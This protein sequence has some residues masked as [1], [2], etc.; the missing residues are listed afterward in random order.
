MLI[1]F[2]INDESMTVHKH[3]SLY[4]PGKASYIKNKIK[5]TYNINILE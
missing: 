5:K 2:L 1:M 4:F 3:L